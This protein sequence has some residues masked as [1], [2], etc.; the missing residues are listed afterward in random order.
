[1][2]LISDGS[3]EN[4]FLGLASQPLD[5]ESGDQWAAAIWKDGEWDD[6]C[7]PVTE[8]VKID[9]TSGV[10]VIHC[11]SQILTALTWTGDRGYLIVTYGVDDPAWFREILATARLH[12]EDA[13][14]AAPSAS[15]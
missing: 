12:P 14:Q 7:D 13:T 9:G 6:R 3:N 1:M 5:G 11:P 8:P 15:P 10:I 2:D 4:T